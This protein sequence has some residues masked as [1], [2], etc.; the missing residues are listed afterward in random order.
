MLG[1]NL[2]GQLGDGTRTDSATPVEATGLG[3]GVAAIAAGG[4]HTC[5]L[6]D[7]GALWCWGW[8][9]AG[10]LGDGTT[11]DHSVPAPVDAAG[12]FFYAVAAGYKHTCALTTSAGVKCWGE[13]Q[14]GQLGDGAH[15]DR[16]KPVDVEGLRITVIAIS[17]GE[18]HT[19]AVMN[20]H[21]LECWGDNLFGQL[22]DDRVKDSAFP[23]VVGGWTDGVLA[24]SAGSG[25]TCALTE[26]G[27][28]CWGRNYFGQLGDGTKDSSSR[29]V[30]VVGFSLTITAIAAGGNHTCGQSAGGGVRC[31]GNNA[32][33]QLGDGT[34][35]DR[36]TPVDVVGLS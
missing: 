11:M 2:S 12:T 25:H 1:E 17:L 26:A 3:N 14:S 18:A 6:Q 29:P 5:A 23:M 24:V 27:A 13:N 20:N 9:G 16:L 30:K 8:N 36:S 7:S 19:C 31:W 35:A 4:G 22:A 34:A 15:A 32:F 33:G 10:Q 21:A 28:E